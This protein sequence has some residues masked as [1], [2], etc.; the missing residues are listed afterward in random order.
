HL[1]PKD[2]LARLYEHYIDGE[3]VK[4]EEDWNYYYTNYF[5]D[6]DM[7]MRYRGGGIGHASTHAFTRHLEEEAT[8]GDS[9]IPVYDAHGDPIET[10]DDSEGAGNDEEE[11]KDWV[12]NLLGAEIGEDLEDSSSSSGDGTSDDSDDE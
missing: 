3:Y 7:V 12:D 6:R 1:L 5:A 4:E 2:S 11:G 9:P 8:E 10:A